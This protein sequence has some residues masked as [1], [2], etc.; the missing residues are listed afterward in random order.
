[1]IYDLEQTFIL[2]CYYSTLSIL[3]VNQSYVSA[4]VPARLLAPG[5]ALLFTEQAGS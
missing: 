5:C 4:S 1:M 3:L 2:H